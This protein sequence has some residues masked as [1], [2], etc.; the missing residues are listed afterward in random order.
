MPGNR[1]ASLERKVSDDFLGKL[2]KVAQLFREIMI[3]DVGIN[4]QV[5]MYQDIAKANHADHALSKFAANDAFSPQYGED[6]LRLIRGRQRQL[7]DQVTGNIHANLNRKLE[8][9]LYNCL[10]IVIFE[11]LIE[12]NLLY[13]P[14]V[15]QIAV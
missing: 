2:L 12:G 4:F 3:D 1:V 6:I 11:V 10:D 14:Q 9:A 8:F 13:L 5:V 7:T 15:L